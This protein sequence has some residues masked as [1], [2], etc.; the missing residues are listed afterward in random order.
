M[1]E[2]IPAIWVVHDGKD[3]EAENIF[4][5]GRI[6]VGRDDLGD[7][8]LLKTE[9]AIR[10]R[11]SIT[12]H[13]KDPRVLTTWA[14]QLYGFTYDMRI[15]DIIVY[16]RTQDREIRLGSIT[17][18]YRYVSDREQFKSERQV[19]WAK[20]FPR[21]V[22][23]K[24]AL[25]E[26]AHR[27]SAFRV[28]DAIEEVLAKYGSWSEVP[29][30][31]EV[32]DFI[33]IRSGKHL[34]GQGFKTSIEERIAIERYAMAKA[35]SYY[36]GQGWSVNP[37]VHKNEPF[38]LHCTR[39][40]GKELRVEVKGTTSEGTNILLTEGEVKHAR[41]HTNVAL[42]IVANITL[43]SM[44]GKL[45]PSGGTTIIRQPWRV[46]DGELTPLAYK[47]TTPRDSEV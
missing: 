15:G 13:G 7:L 28:R 18:G 29:E 19:D 40:N 16:P 12:H 41:K 36:R 3:D 11:L 46:D 20:T 24:K 23:S 30:I 14:R 6:A 33:E 21:K 42:F 22:F 10:K 26:F 4:D 5:Q 27:Y 45:E 2:G 44:S 35:E 43:S 37:D 8:R 31:Q 25:T 32:C 17:G 1:T 34:G 39:S 47:Y 9:E 38:D